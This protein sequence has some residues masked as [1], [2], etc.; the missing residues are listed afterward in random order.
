MYLIQKCNLHYLNLKP[1]KDGN[2]RD[3]LGTK[4]TTFDIKPW[5][6]SKEKVNTA[7]FLPRYKCTTPMPCTRMQGFKSIQ[8]VL[9]NDSR[10]FHI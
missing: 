1:K 10:P 3:A 7:E 6:N 8:N 4:R 2:V 5:F 9:R